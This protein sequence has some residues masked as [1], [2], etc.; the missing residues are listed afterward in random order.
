[1]FVVGYGGD[2][3]H[4]YTLAGVSFTGSA[5]ALITTEGDFGG[6]DL[7]ELYPVTDTNIAAGDIVSFIDNDSFALTYATA[8]SSYALAGGRL[9][10]SRYYSV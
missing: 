8:E 10:G 3:V 2:D 7:A 6:A 5:S 9:D 4:E 1:M